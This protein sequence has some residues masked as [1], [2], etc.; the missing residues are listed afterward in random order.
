MG[1]TPTFKITTNDKDMTAI[2]DPHLQHIKLTDKVGFEADTV[3]MQLQDAGDNLAL[4]EP[5]AILDVYLGYQETALQKLGQYI[6]DEI[7]TRG[8]PAQLTIRGKSADMLK[9]LKAPKTR[10]WH[11]LAD[12][13][14][15]LNLSS[16]LTVHCP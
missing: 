6:I 4:P 15:K 1:L 12:S 2:L 10:A 3:E 11:H 9:S 14:G 7:E 13:N 16:L 5:G 8:P